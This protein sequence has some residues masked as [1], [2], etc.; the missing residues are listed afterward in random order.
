MT[1]IVSLTSGQVLNPQRHKPYIETF[2]HPNQ[3]PLILIY[4]NQGCSKHLKSG[5]ATRV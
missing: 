5:Q 2:S 3:D 4:L 1:V